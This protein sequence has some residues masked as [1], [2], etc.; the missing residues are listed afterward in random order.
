MDISPERDDNGIVS[1]D[2]LITLVRQARCE[3][4][5]AKLRLEHLAVLLMN[6]SVA[7]VAEAARIAGVSRPTIYAWRDL[8]LG[9]V[10][11]ER[12]LDSLQDTKIDAARVLMEHF[13]D[14]LLVAAALSVS[15]ERVRRWLNPPDA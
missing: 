4:D 5:R 14:E 8:H 13:G 7:T 3:S 12:F 11:Y 15:V 2:E 6:T 1:A 10:G 9:T